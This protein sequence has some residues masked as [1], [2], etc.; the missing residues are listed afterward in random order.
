M[1]I[2]QLCAK[3]RLGARHGAT[4]VDQVD[5]VLASPCVWSAA[6]DG[7]LTLRVRTNNYIVTNCDKR[8][9]ENG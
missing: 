3:L 7:L 4:A 8:T 6:G 1:L 9:A 5:Q 2:Q